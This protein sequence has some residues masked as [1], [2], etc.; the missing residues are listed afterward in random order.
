MVSYKV[1]LARPGTECRVADET[2]CL[3]G[4][5]TLLCADDLLKKTLG[6][7]EGL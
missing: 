6:L 7:S 4:Q 2:S 1:S 5:R 3:V